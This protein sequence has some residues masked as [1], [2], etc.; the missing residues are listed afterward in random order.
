MEKFD[1]IVYLMENGV[2]PRMPV[3]ELAER[4]TFAELAEALQTFAEE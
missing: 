2:L 4:Y 1:L 3:D